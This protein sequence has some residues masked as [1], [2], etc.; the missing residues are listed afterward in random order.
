MRASRSFAI[1]FA[2]IALTVVTSSAAS[3]QERIRQRG[4]PGDRVSSIPGERISSFRADFNRIL[5]HYDGVFRRL[6]N[7]RGIRL[8]ADARQSLRAVSDEQLARVFE[9]MGVPDLSAAVQAAE[10]LVLRTPVLP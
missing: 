2:I 8:T 4:I 1:S 10:V 7:A 9:R 5:D 6:E 3:A